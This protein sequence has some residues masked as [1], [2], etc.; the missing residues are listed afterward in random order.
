MSDLPLTLPTDAIGLAHWLKTFADPVRLRLLW[1]LADGEEHCVCRLTAAL[2][3]PQSTVSRHLGRLRRAGLVRGRREGTWMHYALVP[4]PPRRRAVLDAVRE[5][6]AGSEEA[7]TLGADP[8]TACEV[9]AAPGGDDPKPR[10]RRS[11]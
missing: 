3:L 4:Q 1:L 7:A 9:P 5:L 11:C 2:G 10:R 6:L 8:G